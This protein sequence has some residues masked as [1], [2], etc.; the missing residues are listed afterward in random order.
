M[1]FLLDVVIPVKMPSEHLDIMRSHLNEIPENFRVI[2]VLDFGREISKMPRRQQIEA[3]NEVFIEGNFGSPGLAR[4]AGAKICDSRFIGFWDV[5]DHPEISRIPEF[6]R[7][8]EMSTADIGIGNWVRNDDANKPKGVTPLA[9]GKYPGIWRFIFNLE[10]IKDIQFSS[11]YW[12]ED[13]A[14]LATVLSKNPKIYVSQEIIYT[15]AFATPGALTQ[16][17]KLVGDLPNSILTCLSVVNRSMGANRFCI[18][19]MIARQSITLLKNFRHDFQIRALLNLAFKIIS[20]F[21]TW[22]SIRVLI[23]M[24]HSW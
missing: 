6:L 10:Y 2:Y 23:K 13:Q 20:T 3:A 24:V 14:F 9:V 12:G 7:Q 17:R 15:Y 5:D 22:G 4:N 1:E 8:M 16:N 19:V 21:C 18:L 11:L